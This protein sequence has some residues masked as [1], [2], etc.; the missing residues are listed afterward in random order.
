MI[1]GIYLYCQDGIFCPPVLFPCR[2]VIFTIGVKGEAGN[3]DKESD[4][5]EIK[6]VIENVL[7]GHMYTSPT[8]LSS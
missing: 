7:N 5:E 8:F 4:A 1:V 6:K 2:R 3:L